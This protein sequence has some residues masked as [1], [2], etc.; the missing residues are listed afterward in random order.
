MRAF[1][2][3]F[4]IGAFALVASPAFADDPRQAGKH[5]QRGVSLYGEADYRAA[6]VEFKRAYALSPNPAV[7]YNVGETQY[8]LQDYAAAL[9]TFEHFLAESAPGD[10]HRTEVESD[11]E[12][13]RA[14]VGHVAITTVPPG[15]EITIDDQPAGKTP[16]DRAALVSIGHRKVT[17]TISGR[18]PVTR[19]VD[20]AADDNVSV[21]LAMPDA[22]DGQP[23]QSARSDA[24]S[25]VMDVPPPARTGQ[26]LRVLGWTATSAFAAGAIVFGALAVRESHEL[27]ADRATFP[28]SPSTLNHDSTL[29]TTYSLIADSLAVGAIVIGG[30]TLL[31][32]L[33][34]N[35]SSTPS[36]GSNDTPQVVLG[37]GSA[38]LFMT[39]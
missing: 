35:S 17:A 3:A 1:A 13:L 11:L 7:L 4:T 25:R 28:A 18:P 15:A 32:T 38:R 23:S 26:T 36:R 6:L 14:R 30:T 2:L 31:S 10:G 33:L 27:A 34:S 19:Y 37:P 20:V 24:G 5:F 9:T 21:T 8:Q 16:L 12:V 22:T 39:F 29:T